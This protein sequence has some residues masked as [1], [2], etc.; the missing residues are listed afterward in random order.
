[1][2]RVL[3]MNTRQIVD[4]PEIQSPRWSNG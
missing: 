1:M 2:V 4:R 3:N